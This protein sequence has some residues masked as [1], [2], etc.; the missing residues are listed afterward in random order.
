MNLPMIGLVSALAGSASAVAVFTVSNWIEERKDQEY[1]VQ[2][3]MHAQPLEVRPLSELPPLPALPPGQLPLDA[4]P[5]PGYTPQPGS[6]M[7]SIQLKRGMKLPTN[8]QQASAKLILVKTKEFV[9]ETKDPIWSVQLVAND[10]VLDQ[11][12]A[13]VGRFNKQTSNRHQ[14]G[15]KS[16]LPIGT[17]AIDRQGIAAAP[18][19]DPELGKGYWVP[20]TPLFSTQRSA[21]GFHQDPS[22]GRKNGESGTSG[23]IGLQSPEATAKLVDW[24]K[25]YNIRQLIVQ[26]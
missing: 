1:L 3:S 6:V 20:V 26:S 17:Y 9:K 14:A 23:C 12:P 24:I 16:P 25:H 8:K 18:F 10:Q 5:T 7:P 21:L 2:A 19:D 15:N 11:L 13:L 22:W 4:T